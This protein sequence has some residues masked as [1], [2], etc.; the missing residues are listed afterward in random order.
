MALVPYSPQQLAAAKQ[1]LGEHIVANGP[2]VLRVAFSED[3]QTWQE[4]TGRV[5]STPSRNALLFFPQAPNGTFSP[6][7]MQWP[8]ANVAYSLFRPEG[9]EVLV[10]P[11]LQSL[12]TLVDGAASSL[13]SS[14]SATRQHLQSSAVGLHHAVAETASAL[15]AAVGETAATLHNALHSSVAATAGT[16]QQMV[17]EER[18]R[19]M[20][21][22]EELE[23]MRR[24]LANDRRD[25]QSI[26]EELDQTTQALARREEALSV[27]EDKVRVERLR[28]IASR[29][30]PSFSPG[31]P[32]AQGSPLA[33]DA[34]RVFQPLSQHQ[35]APQASS[36][37]IDPRDV[38]IDELTKLVHS[39]LKT[40]G[41]DSSSDS[42][43]SS[44][45]RLSVTD[46][47]DE[48]SCAKSLA[49]WAARAH[50][51][52]D[53]D[54]FGE[55][56]TAATMTR[57][58][59][60]AHWR[61]Y[62]F[63]EHPSASD[64]DRQDQVIQAILSHHAA[65]QKI[66]KSEEVPATIK[67]TVFELFRQSLVNGHRYKLTLGKV[68]RDAYVLFPSL[69]SETRAAN[70]IATRKYTT[71][72]QVITTKILTVAKYIQSTVRGGSG[73]DRSHSRSLS[74]SRSGKSKKDYRRSKS[75][76]KEPSK[77]KD[78]E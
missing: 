49:G 18:N 13:A 65:V 77:D 34:S 57:A 19:L 1:L 3:G 7:G 4:A 12:Q 68:N 22:R 42:S 10:A 16:F 47:D 20:A 55:P 14:V 8:V 61:R 48:D 78:D 41:A 15:H 64:L 50:L 62:L 45:P 40:Q 63:L 66:A 25:A 2:L 9:P 74:Q 69:V 60:D 11:L 32:L 67:R 26:R 29:Q 53:K 51:I 73:G 23:R 27:L 37:H 46:D 71:I 5:C 58:D 24:D 76:D 31:A 70:R 39:L 38:R 6:H 56:F 30:L 72:Q 17:V 54:K 28:S 52:E 59:L 75:K 44:I 35:F 21:E 36:A 33:P 43:A